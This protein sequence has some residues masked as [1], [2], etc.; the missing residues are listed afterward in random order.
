[1]NSTANTHHQDTTKLKYDL[2]P[3]IT[4]EVLAGLLE[5]HSECRLNVKGKQTIQTTRANGY[6][7][8]V[9]LLC[10]RIISR[11]CRWT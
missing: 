11:P 10:A 8:T 6:Y 4:F 9:C 2:V 1:M 5:L 3:H 7:N